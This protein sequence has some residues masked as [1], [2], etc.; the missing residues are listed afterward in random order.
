MTFYSQQGVMKMNMSVVLNA[1]KKNT[2][3]ISR[4][5]RRWHNEIDKTG[6][7]LRDVSD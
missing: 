1:L 6:E 7:D 5:K 4:R 2:T 3:V